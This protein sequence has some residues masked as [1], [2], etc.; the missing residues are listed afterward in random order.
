MR[1]LSP[2]SLSRLST[3]CRIDNVHKLAPFPWLKLLWS[4]PEPQGYTEVGIAAREAKGATLARLSLAS[5]FIA[6]VFLPYVAHAKER[7]R[8]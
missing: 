1:N 7:E 5:Q 2:V 3:S 4:P 8:Q 6:S